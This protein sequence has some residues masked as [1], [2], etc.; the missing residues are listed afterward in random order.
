MVGGRHLI[1]HRQHAEDRLH[2]AG[3]TEQMPG[4]RLGRADGQLVGV[5]AEGALDGDGLGLVAQRRRGRVR[6]QVLHV[7]RG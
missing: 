5:L 2:H 1:A 3:G 6:I 4:H 7:A